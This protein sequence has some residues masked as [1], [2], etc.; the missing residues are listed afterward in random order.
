M[1]ATIPSELETAAVQLFT[2]VCLGP[3][4]MVQATNWLADGH[5]QAIIRYALTAV[6]T[7][8][9]CCCCACMY[10]VSLIPNVNVIVASPTM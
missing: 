8:Q 1:S 6:R 10:N 5:A 4:I 2:M 9:G 7:H 3:D